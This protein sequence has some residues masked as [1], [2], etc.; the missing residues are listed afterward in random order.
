[1]KKKLHLLAPVNSIHSAKTMAKAGAD[2]FFV[3]MEVPAFKDL[4]FTVRTKYCHGGAK[5][6]VNKEEFSEIVK[7]AHD[8]DT[9]V[10]LVANIPTLK[11]PVE[12]NNNNHKLNM[13]D[14]Y[15][16]MIQQGSDLGADAVIVGGITPLLKIKEAGIDLPIHAGTFFNVF[17]PGQVSFLKYLGV[18]RI[19][20]PFN[21][22]IEDI[23]KLSASGGIEHEVFGHFSCSSVNGL[24]LLTHLTRKELTT[25]M[26]CGNRYDV[27]SSFCD[28]KNYPF[29]KLRI[30]CSICSL[31]ELIDLNVHGIKI[32]GRAIPLFLTAPVVKIYRRCIDALYEGASIRELKREYLSKNPFW[33]RNYC[34]H[35]S[36]KYISDE[37]LK[38]EI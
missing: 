12:G 22:S 9:K 38:A 5:T 23:R 29:L 4:T 34:A 36:C 11:R 3:A 20:H 6:C 25:Y 16:K 18:K 21:I 37:N 7:I 26:S 17:N 35:N 30:E 24:C 10:N 14:L 32:V 2:E 33:S 13:S 31:S 19:T 8:A 28:L 15:L 27:R 1:M